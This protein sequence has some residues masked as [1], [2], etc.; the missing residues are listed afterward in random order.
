MSRSMTPAEVRSKLQRTMEMIA[1]ELVA[2]GVDSI[3]MEP[4][5]QYGSGAEI[6]IN[7]DVDCVPHM[8]YKRDVVIPVWR[9][10]DEQL[11]TTE[12]AADPDLD[13]LRDGR[14]GHCHVALF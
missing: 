7:I 2:N 4:P 10:E 11:Q 1:E 12:K 14:I 13:P 9:T 6:V 8:Y 5:R 3:Y